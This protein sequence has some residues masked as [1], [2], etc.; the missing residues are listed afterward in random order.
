MSL[1]RIKRFLKIAQTLGAAA[2]L[3]ALLA[4]RATTQQ[5]APQRE[6]A[7]LW[8]RYQPTPAIRR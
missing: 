1:S 6:L 2:A 5:G 7:Q 8:R 4:P 3:L